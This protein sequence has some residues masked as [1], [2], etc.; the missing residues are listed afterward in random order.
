MIYM[1]RIHFLDKCRFCFYGYIID[2][3]EEESMYEMNAS[4]F[5][6]WM[7]DV[8]VFYWYI[9]EYWGEESMY[10]MYASYFCPG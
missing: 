5:F 6:P 10:E 8:Y 3:R 9:V 1:H 4:I 2:Y 7:N